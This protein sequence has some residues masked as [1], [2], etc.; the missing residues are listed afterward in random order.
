MI[1][2]PISQI[3]PP[4]DVSQMRWTTKIAIGFFVA[5]ALVFFI[6]LMM[7]RFPEAWVFRYSWWTIPA[8]LILALIGCVFLL[9]KAWD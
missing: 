1:K 3:N 5:A 2:V 7:T 8:A 4:S 9:L 6:P